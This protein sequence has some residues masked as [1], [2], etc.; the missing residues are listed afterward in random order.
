MHEI[1]FLVPLQPNRACSNLYHQHMFFFRAPPAQAFLP[2]WSILATAPCHYCRRYRSLGYYS[3]I[4][5]CVI[6]PEMLQPAAV[7]QRPIAIL[8]MRHAVV[9]GP[10]SLPP[11]LHAIVVWS[12]AAAPV[13][14]LAARRLHRKVKGAHAL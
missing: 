2:S 5:S 14:V 8:C 1:F 4:H 11:P 12:L 3:T 7:T 13:Q 10:P 9:P 6:N